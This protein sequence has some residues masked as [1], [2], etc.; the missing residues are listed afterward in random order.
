MVDW[1]VVN[2]NPDVIFFGRVICLSDLGNI[3]AYY[4]DNIIELV[5]CAVK[6]NNENDTKTSNLI[7]LVMIDTIT[8]GNYFELDILSIA[9]TIYIY[10][11]P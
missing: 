8:S 9:M 7:I 6:E 10:V 2:M 4:L 5:K 11:Y 1:S 3:L